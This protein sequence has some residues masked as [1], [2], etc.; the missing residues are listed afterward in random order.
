M[1]EKTIKNYVRKRLKELGAFQYW[2]V[3]TVW[4]SAGVDVLAC[5]KSR[6]IA[7]E[8]KAPGKLP[9]VRQTLI[10]REVEK[11]GGRIFLI[12]SAEKVN[13]LTDENLR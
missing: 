5:Y 9:T 3:P 11:A 6:F 12:D 13:L 7:I 4:G 2:P 8:T 10:L 1:K